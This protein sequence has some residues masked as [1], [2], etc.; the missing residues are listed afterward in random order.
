MHIK[1]LSIALTVV[2]GLVLPSQSVICQSSQL[3]YQKKDGR[4]QILDGNQ[5]ILGYQYEFMNPPEGVSPAYGRSGF[6]HPVNTPSGKLLT[7]IQPKDHYHHYGIW[8]PWT[9]VE[10]KGD[11]VDF[12]NLNQKTGLVAFDSFKN[13]EKTKAGGVKYTAVHNHVKTKGGIKETVLTEDQIVSIK[14][15]TSNSYAIDLESVYKCA[16]DA[17][18]NILEY[19]YAGLGWR[20]TSEWK[21]ENCTVLTSAGIPREGS[22]GSLAKWIL[23]QGSFETG[24]GGILM[25][26]HPDNFNHTPNQGEPIR[27]WPENSNGG[28]LFVN[29]SPT[30]NKDWKLMPGKNYHLKYRLVV[31]DDKMDAATAE[32]HYTSFLKEIK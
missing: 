2:L 12:W 31:F 13:I 15:L 10:V 26:S 14:K 28:Y 20:A 21:K 24:S 18:F 23:S 11:T 8:N 9:H 32:A 16:T 1:R 3:S 17:P 30:K 29:F 4:L 6:M 22:D 5:E 19:R 7:W 25:L 27:I